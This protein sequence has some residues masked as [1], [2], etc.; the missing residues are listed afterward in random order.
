VK[1]EIVKRPVVNSVE[2][3]EQQFQETWCVVLQETIQNLVDSM[4]HRI[5]EAI[6]AHGGHMHY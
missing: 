5:A 4:P 3:L 1:R 2:Q 6:S